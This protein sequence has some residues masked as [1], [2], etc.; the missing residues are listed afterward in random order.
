MNA[1]AA[2]TGVL[3]LSFL[4]LSAGPSQAQPRDPAAFTTSPA[5]QQPTRAD[6]TLVFRT[7]G[8]MPRP[9]TKWPLAPTQPTS[10]VVQ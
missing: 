2:L 3:C 6:G 8:A 10:F 7:K 5:V 9:P 4:L 1:Y